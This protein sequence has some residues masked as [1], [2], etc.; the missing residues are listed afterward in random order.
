MSVP[1]NRAL[2]HFLAVEKVVKVLFE[3]FSL[4]LRMNIQNLFGFEDCNCL[5]AALRSMGFLRLCS[6]FRAS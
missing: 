3:L 2:Y 6:F 1:P 5:K 4:Q